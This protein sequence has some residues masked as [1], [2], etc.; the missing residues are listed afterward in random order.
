[1]LG[2]FLQRPCTGYFLAQLTLV[3]TNSATNFDIVS[4][5]DKA[6]YRTCLR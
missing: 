1:M 3:P 2:T 6:A 4:G 5:V